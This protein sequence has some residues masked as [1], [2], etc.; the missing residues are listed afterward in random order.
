MLA[1]AM[2]QTT[3]QLPLL[4]NCA[5][6]YSVFSFNEDQLWQSYTE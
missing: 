5:F 2:D 4:K 1:R 3:E 6:Y